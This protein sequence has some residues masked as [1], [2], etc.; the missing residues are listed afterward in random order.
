M[1]ESKFHSQTGRRRLGSW[2]R[3]LAGICLVATMAGGPAMVAGSMA[4]G[5][6]AHIVTPAPNESCSLLSISADVRAAALQFC[7]IAHAGN[8]RVRLK[9]TPDA[10]GTSYVIYYM[11]DRDPNRVVKFDTVTGAGTTVSHLTNG[12]TYHFWIAADVAENVVSNVASATPAAEAPGAPTGLTATPGN[13]QVTLKWNPPASDGGATVTG[14]KVYVGSTAGFTRGDP[15]TSVTGTI[16]TV[17]NLTNG[18]TY[19]FQVTAVNSAGEGQASEVPAT[20]AAEAPG[21]PT[22]LTATPGNAQVTLKWNPPASDGGATVTGYDLYAGTTADFSGQAPVARVPGTIATV[23]GLVVGT[24]YHFQVKAVNRVGAGPPSEEAKTVAVTVPGAPARLT[25]A[26][27]KSQVRLSWAAPASNGGL[28]ISGYVIYQGASTVSGLLIRATGYTVTGLT[29]G[30]MYHFRVAAV[31]AVGQG[32]PSEEVSAALPPLSTPTGTPTPTPTG[33]PTPTPTG[34]P[35]P[36]PTGTPTPTPTGTPTPTPTGTPTPTPTGTPTPTPTGT[37]TPTP[38]GTPTPSA[39]SSA[40]GVAA[41]AGLTADP[42]NSQVHLAWTALT[43]DG[44]SSAVSYK[45]YFATALGVQNSAALGTTKGTD[46]IV[47]GLT[48]GTKYWFMVTAVNAAGNESPYSTEV[49]AT[50]TELT[51]GPIVSLP[52]GM[53]KQLIVLLGALGAMAVAGV[54][55]LVTR[56]RRFRSRDRAH[57]ARSDQPTDMPSDVR[58]VPDTSRPDVMNVRDTGQ[59]PTHTIRLEPH[60]G[61]A[62]TTIKEGRP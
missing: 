35:T 3:A 52:S 14:Y 8:E 30:T 17:P 4:A 2:L 38:T 51:S 7:L 32:S 48:N 31:N 49:S 62:T 59:E 29:N 43:P 10:Q 50:P 11:S 57:S 56:R 13:A 27:G 39:S 60:P 41:P 61:L 54:S 34:T 40:P 16:A 55:T 23:K 44:G 25:A 42:G 21:A 37:P 19:Y 36:T 26:P 5:A 12:T 47:A 24:T 1:D 18:T 28:P 22:G 15:F 6:R 33:T 9:W 20:P 45:V 46:A 53:P 58:A